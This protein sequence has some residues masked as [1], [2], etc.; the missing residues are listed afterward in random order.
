M[1]N[2]YKNLAELERDHVGEGYKFAFEKYFGMPLDDFYKEFDDFML[3][4]RDEQ[5]SI[6]KLNQ[7]LITPKIKFY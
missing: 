7:I 1:I 6:L 5:L 2:Y 3:K 4:P